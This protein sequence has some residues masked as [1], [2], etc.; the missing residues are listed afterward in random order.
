MSVAPLMEF[1]Y[2]HP[3]QKGA[4]AGEL[5]ILGVVTFVVFAEPDSPVRGTEL[6][7]RMMIAFGD[8]A[9]AIQGVWRKG[10]LPSINT[11]K[12]NELT[13]KGASIDNAVRH[14]WTVTRARKLG[15]AKVSVI[16]QDG[17]PGNFQ[18][19]DVLIER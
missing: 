6:F 8:D 2:H 7:N 17:S 4:I 3:S 15:F 13:G 16:H 18:K 19:I 1:G 14:A 10:S 9:K 5:D 11:D 12:V